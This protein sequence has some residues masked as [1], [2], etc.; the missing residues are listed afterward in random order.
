MNVELES[1]VEVV[2]V[3]ENRFQ[4]DFDGLVL[5]IHLTTIDDVQEGFFELPPILLVF[6]IGHL[7]I[8]F[9]A[10]DTCIRECTKL[11]HDSFF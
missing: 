2:W 1:I 5:K 9:D 7:N 10:L 8:G 6:G 4:L 3:C 11:P